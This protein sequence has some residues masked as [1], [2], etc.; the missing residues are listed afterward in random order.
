[1]KKK[2]AL[3]LAAV[4]ALTMLLPVGVT[5][6]SQIRPYSQYIGEGNWA[7]TEVWVDLSEYYDSVTKKPGT[8]GNTVTMMALRVE[9]NGATWSSDFQKDF[10]G[11]GTADYYEW[12]EDSF[13]VGSGWTKRPNAAETYSAG[14]YPWYEELLDGSDPDNAL[15]KDVIGIPV[16]NSP[17]PIS[18]PDDSV[19]LYYEFAPVD[20]TK[21][22]IH[23]YDIMGDYFGAR[24]DQRG[25]V[26]IPI[27]YRLTDSAAQ[28]R[29]ASINNQRTQTW[30]LARRTGSLQL[31]ADAPVKLYASSSAELGAIEATEGWG[32]MLTPNGE[33]G[34]LWTLRLEAPAG[35]DWKYDANN[36]KA[37]TLYEGQYVVTSG[38]QVSDEYV[39][40][41]GNHVLWIDFT[42]TNG[43]DAD[44]AYGWPETLSFTG[45]SLAAN[46]S[47]VAGAVNVEAKIQMLREESVIL[48]VYWDR[49]GIPRNFVLDGVETMS[50]QNFSPLGVGADGE[51]ADSFWTA[52]M[53][54]LYGQ[55][56]AWI[57]FWGPG[58]PYYMNAWED[59][60]PT[61][62]HVADYA[63]QTIA[64]KIEDLLNQA[65]DNQIDPQVI[66][67]EVLAID[68]S[69]L[70]DA[71]DVKEV[72][73]NFKALEDIYKEMTDTEI[74]ITA[75]PNTVS[76]FHNSDA[77][78]VVG[79]AFNVLPGDT[80][81]IMFED[82]KNK[83]VE[84]DGE[85]YDTTDA[86]LLDIH[87]NGVDTPVSFDVPIY[88]TVPIPAKFKNKE[89]RLVILHYHHDNSEPELIRPVNNGD[90]TCTFS[91]TGFSIFAFTTE[92]EPVAPPAPVTPSKPGGSSGSTGSKSSST[93]PKPPQV[94]SVSSGSASA[95]TL[96]NIKNAASG[97]TVSVEADSTNLS[98]SVLKALKGKDAT[99]E[100]NFG[101]YSWA[102][103]GSDIERMP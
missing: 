98:L 68:A 100:L 81:E 95:Q 46:G 49:N 26:A 6:A 43:F 32:G 86:V 82:P 67:D 87:I 55:R 21:A 45:V 70:E 65:E 24:I 2:L 5:G 8:G 16:Y 84:I 76:N 85:K 11:T 51:D 75:A 41:G 73:E 78:N 17:S 52:D 3:L 60:E 13:S 33:T 56:G 59:I 89:N 80:V 102:I 79:M 50:W 69:G 35:F 97:E 58:D 101:G 62:L 96:S 22:Y 54:A 57:P 12:G 94:S 90:D 61:I 34:T 23:I 91:V 77:F 15:G 71:L 36:I 72:E 9:L 64:E 31:S 1:M 92:L 88:I 39:N 93:Q 99:L 7:Q 103:N 53:V 44:N 66:K 27:Y 38:L 63:E 83:D 10:D 25:Y 20:K 19:K 30:P 42:A 14:S 4:M 47:A 74:I 40:N 37:E 29:I 28:L 18:M 48:S